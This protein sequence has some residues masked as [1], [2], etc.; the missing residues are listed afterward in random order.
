MQNLKPLT[1]SVFFFAL[2]CGKIFIKKHSIESRCYRTGKYTVCRRYRASFS[3]EILQSGAVKG[4]IATYTEPS[5]ERSGHTPCSHRDRFTTSSETEANAVG[6][7]NDAKRLG[8]SMILKDQE[9]KFSTTVHKHAIPSFIP[10]PPATPPPPPPQP[11]STPSTP[12]PSLHPIFLPPPPPPP[13][14]PP[15]LLRSTH[16]PSS[17]EKSV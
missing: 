9:R 12:P 16:T 7:K 6:E 1:V 3:P 11:S 17:R 10:P 5:C 15:H 8:F 14:P 13:P 4:L 2:E